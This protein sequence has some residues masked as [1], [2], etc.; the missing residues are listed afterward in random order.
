MNNTLAPGASIAVDITVKVID[1]ADR[2]V[3]VAEITS[4]DGDDIDS[5]PNN[6][7][8]DQ[9][10]DEEDSEFLVPVREVCNGIDD[11]ND[12]A[13]DEGF[14]DTTPGKTCDD[15]NDMT[16][17]D[18]YNQDCVCTGMPV[19]AVDC[20]VSAWNIGTCNG[21]TRTDTRTITV[22]PTN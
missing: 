7:D 5:T 13:T 18:V 15:N 21:T 22:Q 11:D 16:T 6:D 2:V 20:K 3:N 19:E 1:L 14:E 12:G 8:G 9:S 17:D 4:D 10:E